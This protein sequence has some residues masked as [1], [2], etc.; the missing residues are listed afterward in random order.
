VQEIDRRR[1]SATRPFRHEFP[2]FRA[3]EKTSYGGIV[4]R[5]SRSI[6]PP[7]RGSQ[8]RIYS[9][10]L[11]ASSTKVR[12][13]TPEGPLDMKGLASSSQAVPAISRCAQGV[14]SANSL[15]N[16]AAVIAPPGRPPTL[17]ISAKALFN[18]SR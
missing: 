16:M 12:T 13:P 7:D 9:C 2:T 1:E 8:V 15:R 11:M 14:L 6:G 18:C 10:Q 4:L 3:I 17:V 5:G